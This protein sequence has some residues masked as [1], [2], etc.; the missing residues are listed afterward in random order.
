VRWASDSIRIRSFINGLGKDFIDLI[1]QDLVSLNGVKIG[2]VKVDSLD[3][4]EKISE[5]LYEIRCAC[6]HSKKTRKGKKSLRLVPYSQDEDLVEL[7]IRL[8]QNLAILCIEKDGQV[9]T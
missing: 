8:V 5:W 4:A 1:E 2:A 7:S 3:L 6:V 9:I